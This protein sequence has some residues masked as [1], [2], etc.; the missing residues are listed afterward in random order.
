MDGEELVFFQHQLV[1]LHMRSTGLQRC[2][3]QDLF[4]INEKQTLILEN[5]QCLFLMPFLVPKRKTKRLI[6]GPFKDL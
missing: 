2:P 5:T 1:E 3:L 6:H 4:L